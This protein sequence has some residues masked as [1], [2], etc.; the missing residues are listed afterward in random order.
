MNISEVASKQNVG[1]QSSQTSN[2]EEIIIAFA[3]RSRLRTY[4]DTDGTTII[5]GHADCHLYEYG[6]GEL[7]LMILSDGEHVRRW[8]GIRKKCLAAG[9]TL[10][11]NGDDEGALS[12]DPNNRQQARLAIK[13]AGARPKRQLSPE[14]RAR[15]RAVGFQKR[16]PALKAVSSDKKPLETGKVG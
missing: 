6:D 9:M 5:R 2:D 16:H 8:A 10:R 1:V 7:A 12:F 15:L 4:R 3:K 13:I 11:Q 14:H